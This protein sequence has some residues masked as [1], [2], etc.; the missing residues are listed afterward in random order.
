MTPCSPIKPYLHTGG[1]WC[2]HL[3]GTRM[4]RVWYWCRAR[5]NW[6]PLRTNSSKDL[7]FIYSKE[8][9]YQTDTDKKLNYPNVF[10]YNHNSKFNRNPL[11]IFKYEACRRVQIRS[12]HYALVLC[13]LCKDD[14]TTEKTTIPLFRFAASRSRTVEGRQESVNIVTW[15]CGMSQN[16]GF[17]RP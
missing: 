4:N 15:S 7:N 13:T 10:V 16:E 6:G 9:E 8:G 14:I 1:T 17:A 5:E 11:S 12:S 3:H 2:L